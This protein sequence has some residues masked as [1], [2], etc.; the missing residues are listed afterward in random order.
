[1]KYT[2]RD[3]IPPLYAQAIIK[4]SEKYSRGDADIST[5]GIIDSILQHILKEKHH[6]EIVV[7][8][9]DLVYSFWGT[10]AHQVLD[11]VD[12]PSVIFKEK[13]MYVEVSGMTIS[14]QPDIYYKRSTRKVLNDFKTPSKKAL[15]KGVKIEYEKQLNVYKYITVENG[16]PVDDLELTAFIRDSRSY[17]KKILTFPVKQYK[18]HRILEY[19]EKRVALL[20]LYKSGI[21]ANIPECTPAERWQDTTVY[22]VMKEGNKKQTGKDCATRQQAER[23]VKYH[24]DKHP[25][26]NYFVKTKFGTNKRCESWCDVSKFCWWWNLPE[27]ERPDT[28]NQVIEGVVINDMSKA[29]SQ[30]LK[31]LK[32]N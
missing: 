11:D 29:T 5:T 10:C 18:H 26:N 3:N 24:K 31:E 8:V 14:G 19:L 6:D 21:L 4:K 20:K 28:H 15:E 13:R 23:I 7:D 25:K 12:D 27:G 2:N 1:M 22:S 17:E 30:V 32:G 16:Y 9:S